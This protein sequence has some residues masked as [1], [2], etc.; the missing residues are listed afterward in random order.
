MYSY[1]SISNDWLLFTVV[2]IMIN[3]WKINELRKQ[4]HIFKYPESKIATL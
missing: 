2:L 3:Y 1:W 4:K